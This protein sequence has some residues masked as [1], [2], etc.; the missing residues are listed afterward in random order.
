[1]HNLVDSLSRLPLILRC[2]VVGWICTGTLAALV[3]V[4]N[5]VGEYSLNSVV[6][7]ALF[8]MVEAF[9]LAGFVGGFVG[10]LV[11]LVAHLTRAAIRRP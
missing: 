10:L 9:V 6:Q 2:V 8:G 4:A 5:V 1:M 7:A 11:G 3:T